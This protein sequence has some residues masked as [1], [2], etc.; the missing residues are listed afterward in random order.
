MTDQEKILWKKIAAEL[1]LTDKVNVYKMYAQ[2]MGVFLEK[3][4][5]HVICPD[6]HALGVIEKSFR[7]IIEKTVKRELDAATVVSFTVGKIERKLKPLL[8]TATV[9]A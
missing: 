2:R 8:P 4:I 1:E 5:L 6:G 7:Q 3:G 9:P